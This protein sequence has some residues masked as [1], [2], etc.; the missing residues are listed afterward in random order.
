[1]D[2]NDF[3][4]VHPNW[5]VIESL[6]RD[7]SQVTL[8]LLLMAVYLDE[9]L[10]AEEVEV[11]TEEWKQLPFVGPPESAAQLA[12]H[13]F[14]THASLNEIVDHPPLF[15]DFVVEAADEIGGEDK[16]IAIFR[17]VA[18][19]A[20]ADQTTERAL[21]FCYAL[22]YELELELDTVEHLLR[23]I[24]ESHESTVDREQGFDHYVPPVEGHE[25]ARKHTLEPYPNP[26]STCIEGP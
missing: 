1:M 21:A 11:L 17:L 24:W 13:M 16:K 25:W 26:F 14:E 19:A 10:T 2:F 3:R 9:Q 4:D 18:M 8:D 20:L 23:S 5:E 22:G 6:D 15:R 12:E 7:E